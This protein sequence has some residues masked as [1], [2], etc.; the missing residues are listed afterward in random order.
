MRKL[1]TTLSTKLC[2]YIFNLTILIFV[3]IAIVFCSYSINREVEQASRYTSLM[4]VNVVQDIDRKLEDVEQFTVRTSQ[5]VVRSLDNQDAMMRII[6]S[7]VE[8]NRSVIIGG[9]IT[10]VPGFYHG[11]GELFMEYASFDADGNLVEKHLGNDEYDYTTMEWYT[12]A[13]ARRRGIWSEPYFDEGGA[14]VLMTTYSLPL[15]DISGNV[16]AVVTADVPLS[17][18][19]ADVDA[20]RPY[21]DSYAFILSKEGT[22]LAHPDEDVILNETYLSRSQDLDCP[23]LAEVGKQMIMAQSGDMRLELEGEDVLAFYTPISRTGW[24]IC[25][26]CPYQTLVSG[27][28]QTARTALIILAAGLV[29]LIVAIR[30]ILVH[31]TRPIGELANSAYR[32]AAGHF[33]D[34]LPDIDTRDELG[35]LHDAFLYMQ[36]SLKTYVSELTE[37]TRARERIE[38]ELHIARD[39]QM[40]MIPQIFSPFPE[41][42]DLDLYA[43]LRPAKEVGGDLYD[44]FIRDQKLFFTIGDV[45]GKGVPAS[46]FMAITRTLFRIMAGTFDSPAQIAA[47]LNGAISEKNEANMFVTMFFGV[48]DLRTGELTFSNA[49]HNPPVLVHPDGNCEWL[50]VKANLPIGVMEEMVYTDQTITLEDNAALVLYTDGLTEAENFHYDQL[51]ED[52]VLENVTKYAGADVREI[53]NQLELLV[54]YFAQDADQSD[55]LTMMALRFHKPEN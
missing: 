5:A 33:N 39:I 21:E 36:R 15:I 49:G 9:S 52:K 20:R 13:V 2:F 34:P 24:S 6:D 17:E 29:L 23:E 7:M 10:F 54:A 41:W 11:Q 4:L 37:T 55:D 16:Y 45:S 47:T 14:D 53:I 25:C 28:G 19:V 31:A 12:E 48:L 40:N 22:Y 1:F 43:F 44:F 30:L 26:V 8:A 51:G 27:I 50:K 38:N 18:L 35:K 46:L 3:A 32:I 42:K